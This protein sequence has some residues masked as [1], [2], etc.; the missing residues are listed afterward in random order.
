MRKYPLIFVLSSTNADLVWEMSCHSLN[1]ITVQWYAIDLNSSATVHQ[2]SSI[3]VQPIGLDEV[4]WV[5]RA[6]LE[7]LKANRRYQYEIFA[8]DNGKR[9]SLYPK[10]E[11]YWVGESG[12][13][14]LH[15]GLISDNQSGLRAFMGIL[16]SL[17]N[18]P[19]SY[20][21]Q[22]ATSTSAKVFPHY[23]IHVGDAVQSYDSLEQWQTHF[24]D[25]LSSAWSSGQISGP[26]PILYAHGNHDQDV[27]NQYL[28]TTGQRHGENWFSASLGAARFVVLDSQLPNRFETQLDWLRREIHLSAWRQASFRIAIVHMA[29]FIEYWDPHA[30]DELGEKH[31]GKYVRTQ[32][33]PIL[34]SGG[35]DLI[36]SGHQHAY[37]RGWISNEVV[38]ELTKDEF[39]IS[40][41]KSEKRQRVR[42]MATSSKRSRDLQS[43]DNFTYSIGR[44]KEGAMITVIGGAGGELDWEQVENWGFY[45]TSLLG[46]HHFAVITL[47]NKR[48]RLMWRAYDANK[49]LIDKFDLI[50]D[51]VSLNK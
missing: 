45:E 40:M 34:M 31:W 44:L 30:W 38:E 21:L 5:Y 19:A 4:H 39:E 35:V 29:P 33:V 17:V 24:A 36:V 42:L 6:H 50:R 11:F 47:D 51:G 28:Y 3:I 49:Q 7:S 15:I 32:L 2:Y 26:P 27:N 25:P 46:R 1:N 8:V 37:S 10:H 23:L 20:P 22:Y 48:L 9:T 12:N 13:E 16:H 41:N 14:M 18:L 43:K